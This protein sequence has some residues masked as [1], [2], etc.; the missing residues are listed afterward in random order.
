MRLGHASTLGTFPGGVRDRGMCY[1]GNKIQRTKPQN[2]KRY[3]DIF[4]SL[5]ANINHFVQF[6]KTSVKMND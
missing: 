6:E 5:L 4:S 1:Q 2:L 3:P